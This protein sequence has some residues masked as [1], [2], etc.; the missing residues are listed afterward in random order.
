MKNP[1]DKHC[2]DRELGCHSVCDE[3][4][5]YRAYL[6]TKNEDLRK[7]NSI[8]GY[9][10]IKNDRIDRRMRRYKQRGDG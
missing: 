4:K 1:C 5:A 9:K 3:Y 10:K 6:D 7:E 8:Y 2:L